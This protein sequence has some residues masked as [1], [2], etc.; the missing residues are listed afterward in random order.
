[1]RFRLLLPDGHRR[2]LTTP[3]LGRHV[4]PQRARR[5]RG[6][7]VRGPRP[8]GHRG[9]PVRGL[10][11]AASDQ[12][13]DTE[14]WRSSTTATTR[15]LDSMAA[16]LD[17]LAEL[18]GRP[19]RSWARC[20]SWVTGQRR[21]HRD[22]RRAGAAHA[23]TDSSWSAT[24]PPASPT[25]PWRR[26]MDPTPRSISSRIASRPRRCCSRLRDR[27]HHPA[28]GV[29]RGRARSAGRPARGRRT[30]RAGADGRMTGIERHRGMLLAFAFF[31]VVFTM[32]SFIRVIR[33]WAW[34]SASVSTAR[35]R[36]YSKEGTPTMGGLLIILVVIGV[37]LVIR[38]RGRF[39]DPGTFAP[40]ATLA[41]V[42][43]LGTV[44]DWL[45]ARTGDGIRARHKLIWQTVV[46]LVVGVADP[47]DLRRQ[48]HRGAVRR[49]LGIDPRL[50][51]L[52]G[53]FAIVATSNGGEHHRRPRRPLGWVCWC[54]RSSASWPS[55]RST[56][57]AQPNL[58]ILCAHR[59]SAR[60]LGFLWFN[61][62]PGAGVH[63][64][65][66]CAVARRDARG[67]GAHHR[68]GDAAA[69]HRPRVRAGDGS[70]H[71]PGPVVQV[72]GQTAVPDGAAPS[73]L[74]AAAAGPRRRSRSGSGSSA[75]S[76]RS[77]GWPSS[78]VPGGRSGERR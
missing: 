64:R 77:S 5:G 9:G 56:S 55:R 11:R 73:P 76:P 58:A 66:R 40:L 49:A 36:H 65:L 19:P 54:S 6:R 57:P 32:P 68:P 12:L 33:G 75:S 26:V 60:L 28:Q 27:R 13:V 23:S 3:A 47:G 44:D 18:P 51:I 39:I 38:C 15:H 1:M 52:F 59:S 43:A 45:N 20:S 37:S 42:G 48:E 69:G 53:A 24:A 14:P 10:G 78:W 62:H 67:H 8:R 29:P 16:A 63:R 25:V 71:R 70:G 7:S 61:V 2:P 74:R 22:R 21:A 35:S 46:A 41:L 30:S 50:Y 4:G 31:V 34:A 17:L 72:E